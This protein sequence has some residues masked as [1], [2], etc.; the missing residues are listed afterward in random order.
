MTVLADGLEVRPI[1][2]DEFE[3]WD[4]AAEV[5]FFDDDLS[6]ERVHRFRSV[7]ELDRTLGAFVDGRI[8]GTA[9]LLRMSLRVPGAV[10]PMGGVTAVGVLPT[11]RRRG[12]M[13]ALIRRHLDDLTAW[14]EP[15][16]GL[17]A[18]E[19]PIYGRYGFGVATGTM[20]WTIDTTASAFRPE[21]GVQPDIELVTVDEA[22]E[23]FPAIYDAVRSQ[24]AGVPSRSDAMWK[25]WL[26][27]DAA[28]VREGASRRYL[29]RLSD[30]G[31][32]VYRG[33]DRWED[34]LPRG[35]ATVAEHMAT[36]VVAAASLWRYI[37]DLDLIRS[38]TI[39]D[40]P[41]DDLLPLVL[42]D[43]R[44]L[45][46]RWGDALWL[47]MIDLP[48]ALSARQYNGTDALVLEVNDRLCRGNAGR[49]SLEAGTDGAACSLTD[50]EP[51]LR[52][53]VAD[54]SSVYLGGFSVQRLVRAGRVLELRAGAAARLDRLLAID[55]AP[56]CPQ[57]F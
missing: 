47:R 13:T 17:Y 28:D 7:L 2:E 29:A 34:G 20:H 30:R 10:L 24:R 9:A 43:P 35:T 31:Y 41:T 11:H 45:R 48:A 4:R 36:D 19:A 44:A 14:G 53:D 6:P 56:W 42:A 21:V 1:S 23:T 5:P 39:A 38:V 3:A 25:A 8:V 37:F 52:L 27:Y 54:L 12:I 49:W 32:V 40:R 22:L 15:L 26:G 18:A 55:P 16:A 33:K 57:E 50:A 46:G 51:E